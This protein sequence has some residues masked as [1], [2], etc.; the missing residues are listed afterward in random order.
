MKA[1]V[2]TQAQL[3]LDYAPQFNFELDSTE[4]L[5]EALKRGFVTKVGDDQYQ[6]NDNY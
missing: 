4:L 5:A 2:L 1:T 3:F 6:V